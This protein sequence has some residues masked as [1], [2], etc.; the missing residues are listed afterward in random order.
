MTHPKVAKGII[1]GSFA[2]LAAMP[3]LFYAL[4]VQ[5]VSNIEKNTAASV[6][7]QNSVINKATNTGHILF[8]LGLF[9]LVLLITYIVLG[10]R[11]QQREIDDGK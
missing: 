3:G 8:G 6:A 9:F 10:F 11:F 4:V 1:V 7:Q 5:P 2:G